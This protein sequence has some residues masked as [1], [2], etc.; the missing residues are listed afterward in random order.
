MRANNQ[1]PE[2][3][4][5]IPLVALLIIALVGMLA[6]V[7]DGGFGM[8]QRRVAQ[9]A[10]DAGAL[11]GA[12][13]LCLTGDP[14]AAIARADEYAVARNGA[15]TADISVGDG[16][17]TVTSHIPF[18]TFFASVIGFAEVTADAV[19]SAG[20]FVP[21]E[22]TGVLPIAWNCEPSDV[23]GMDGQPRCEM[24]TGPDNPYIIMN[25]K[26][27]DED[28]YCISEGGTVNC[29][30]DG[31]G[32][33]ELLAGGNRSWL[34]LTGSGSDAGNGSHELVDWIQNGFPHGVRIHTWYAGQPGVSN[35]VFQS[36]NSIIGDIVLLPVYNAIS[37]GAPP[38]C[39]DDCAADNVV[40]SNGASATYFHII[41]F[42][43]FVPTCVRSGGNDSCPLYDQFRAADILDPNDKTIEG[44]FI[45]GFAPGLEGQAGN[46]ADAG[47]YTIYL[48][49]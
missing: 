5:S 1:G 29:D 2:R 39:Y 33:D 38:E 18:P 8:Y 27:V 13:E 23:D 36:V 12:R 42:S 35:N 16:I 21:D 7:L 43:L 37:L 45:E 19:A 20:C 26:K 14:G 31:D 10:A 28:V 34:D 46:G 48:T 22:G 25:S 49:Q 47:A 30:L 3:G 32:I 9:N 41:S 17:V 44:Y 6:L 24:E 15:T 11:A 4:Q 40:A